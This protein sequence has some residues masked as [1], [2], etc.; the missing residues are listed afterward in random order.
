MLLQTNKQKKTNKKNKNAND[1]F[2]LEKSLFR[3]QNVEG[4]TN[5]C[6]LEALGSL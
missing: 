2:G 5:K 1:Y 4:S 6:E 3:F